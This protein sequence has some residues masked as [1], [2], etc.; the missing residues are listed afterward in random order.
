MEATAVKY[1][2]ENIIGLKVVNGKLAEKQKVHYNLDGSVSKRHSN[3]KA[4]V[5]SEVYPFTEEEVRKIIAVLD[6]KIEWA[7]GEKRRQIARRNKLMAIIGLN[8]GLRASDI[9]SL[10]FSFFF[11]EDGS[12]RDYYSIMPLKT[13]K[14]KKFVKI[15]FNDAIR[16]S[17]MEYVRLYP[18]S[19]YNQLVFTSQK[20]DDAI[21]V[22]TIYDVIKKAAKEAGIKKN[23]GS[24]SLRKTW[25]YTVWHNAEDKNKALVV[26]QQCFSHSSTQVTARY[27]G[28]MDSELSDM[29]NSVN[30]GYCI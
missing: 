17:I 13:K 27:I 19:D 30:I 29:Y 28:I 6:S 9:R 4:D 26:L 11:D 14:Y 25:G 7:N 18:V 10:T 22:H 2:E 15:F 8:S 12:M 3:A 21:E 1:N 20:G 16:N 5:S 24:H 23:V